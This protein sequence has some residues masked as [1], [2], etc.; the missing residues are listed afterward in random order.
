MHIDCSHGEGGGQV[1]RT[2]LS[3]SAACGIPVTLDN[4]RAGRTTPGLRP[5]HKAVV[6]AM[7][8][9]C[10]ASVSGHDIGSVTLDFSPST[11][12]PGSY[13]VDIGTA[14]SVTLL[15]HAL[16][17]P[18]SLAGG[19]S[20]VEVVGGT[21]VP[22]SP[23]LDYFAHVTLPFLSQVGITATV[24][25]SQRGYYPRG[26]GVVSMDVQ[27]WNERHG[28]GT[29]KFHEPD[30]ICISSCSTGLPERVAVEQADAAASAFSDFDTHI[31]L[32]RTGRGKGSSITLWAMAG[33]IPVGASR[34]GTRG[35]H[36]RDAGAQA[37]SDL[38][39]ALDA[40]AAD[41]YLPDH[42]AVFLA[43]SG[44]LTR[45]PL[46]HVTSH[47]E[48]VLW[49]TQQFVPCDVSLHGGMLSVLPLKKE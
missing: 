32:D 3:L 14:G 12:S 9:V 26:G 36:A 37:A 13:R 17:V 7:S 28:A 24:S 27:P 25:C 48:T 31:A 40:N 39:S 8:A 22:W 2:S 38:R 18:L 23:T 1:L 19:A 16:L 29:L 49:V 35:L 21:D 34:I 15:C 43:L 30:S 42:A 44:G 47:L 6:S 11:P 41:P 20:H 46:S 4:I 10:G 33:D 5:Q 45:I